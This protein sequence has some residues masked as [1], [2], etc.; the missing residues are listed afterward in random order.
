MERGR[1]LMGP[2][3]LIIGGVLMRWEC[4]SLVTEENGLT[5]SDGQS[6]E[7]PCTI[8]S[9]VIAKNW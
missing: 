5:Q 8:K 7:E 4:S 9:C 3:S 1:P 6:S 2:H